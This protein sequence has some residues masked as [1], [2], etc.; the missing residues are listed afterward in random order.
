MNILELLWMKIISDGLK[1]HYYNH[2]LH[3]FLLNPGERRTAGN[4]RDATENTRKFEVVFRAGSFWNFSVDSDKFQ[5]FPA[6]SVRKSW[7]KSGKFPTGIPASMFQVFPASFLEDPARSGGRN[8][9]PGN[10]FIFLAYY[11]FLF[12][13]GRRGCCSFG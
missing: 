7:E 11:S 6:G 13:T 5:C 1:I 9:R 3:L 12:S 2:Y 4:G 8:Y 10:E